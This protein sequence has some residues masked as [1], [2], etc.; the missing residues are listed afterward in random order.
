MRISFRE[1][2][3]L[4][5]RHNRD[6]L[7]IGTHTGEF[8]GIAPTGKNVCVRFAFFD[9]FIDGIVVSEELMFDFFSLYI[10]LGVLSPPKPF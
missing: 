4:L 3:N 5:V 6:E 2:V 1:G 8:M 7:I 9:R 10:Q